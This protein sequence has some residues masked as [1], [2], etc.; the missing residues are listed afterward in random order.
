MST[1]IK[2]YQKT[3]KLSIFYTD[4]QM[5]VLERIITI[6]II[7]TYENDFKVSLTISEK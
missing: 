1:Q 7:E 6:I 5:Y 2:T 4:N 3:F